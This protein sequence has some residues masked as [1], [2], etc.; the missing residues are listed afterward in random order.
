MDQIRTIQI[1]FLFFI[2]ISIANSQVIQRESFESN[3]P[4]PPGWRKFKPASSVSGAF[5]FLSNGPVPSS[6]GNR[7]MQFNSEIAPVNDSAF[8]ISKP[9]DFSACDTN[10]PNFKIKIYRDS[11]FLT[12]NDA[13]AFYIND[14]PDL[15]GAIPVMH[16][17][18]SNIINRPC[19]SF[20]VAT[21][22]SWNDYT[23]ELDASIHN[24]GSRKTYIIITGVSQHGR[25]IYL[26][27]FRVNT[28]PAPMYASDIQ[29]DV[30]FQNIATI[31]SGL[32]WVI[33]IRCIV[34]GNSGN[35]NVAAGTAVRLDSMIFRFIGDDISQLAYAFIV[36]S[37]GNSAFNQEYVSP[38]PS[39]IN[40]HSGVFALY[41]EPDPGS[42]ILRFSP[43][44]NCFHLEYD[45][46]YLWLAYSI[47]INP[48]PGNKFDA[49]LQSTTVSQGVISCPT[50]PSSSFSNIAHSTVSLPGYVI[51]SATGYCSPSIYVNTWGDLIQRVE[52]FSAEP[53]TYIDTYS[54]E[55]CY[56]RCGGYMKWPVRNGTT[57][58]LTRGKNYNFRAQ[59][60]AFYSL[61]Y[62]QAWIDFNDN[63][64]FTDPG[65]ALG[66]IPLP[67]LT[68]NQWMNFSFIVPD[69]AKIGPTRLRI[70]ETLSNNNISPCATYNYGETEDFNIT[71]L[72]DCP[73]TYKLWLGINPDWN[74][75]VNW[76][77]GAPESY[78]DVVIHRS[79]V[80]TVGVDYYSPV[81]EDNNDRI[82]AD[83]FKV[84]ET[85]TLTFKAV[86]SDTLAIING[87]LINNGHI[88]FNDKDSVTIGSDS[89]EHSFYTPFCGSSSDA[90]MQILYSAT[91][92]LSK[93]LS[94]GTTISE[95]SFYVI[96]V[97]SNNQP[98]KNST[99]PFSGFSVSYGHVS[100][101]SVEFAG[102]YPMPVTTNIYTPKNFNTVSGYNLLVLDQPIV[103][104]G[105]SSI[106]LQ[107]CFDNTNT[108]FNDFIYVSPTIG[109][110]TTLLLTSNN[111]GN[112]CSLIPGSGISNNLF[113]S[114]AINRPNLV[115][116]I[117]REKIKPIFSLKGDLLN[118][119]NL[120]TGQSQFIMTADGDQHL[121]SQDSLI[122]HELKVHKDN[123]GSKV[124]LYSNINIVDSL[125]LER[126]NIH[127]N[128]YYLSIL[129]NMP[130]TGNFLSFTGPVTRPQ[131]GGLIICEDT[132]GG[133]RWNI[134]QWKGSG[135]LEDHYVI[136]FG[137]VDNVYIP[138]SIGLKSGN[139][140]EITM[141]TF[142][143]SPSNL[144]YPAGITHLNGGT[145]SNNSASAADR[146]YFI[147]K[148]G[149][150]PV[151][152]LT[153]RWTA[154]ER[155]VNSFNFLSNPARSFP[156]RKTDNHVGGWL[157]LFSQSGTST[158]LNTSTPY[159]FQFSSGS[160]TDSLRLVNF[161]WPEVLAT[162]AP[163]YSPAG[164]MP[165]ELY[166]AI[167]G[168]NNNA[169][170][171]GYTQSNFILKVFIQ[172]YY[173]GQNLNSPLFNSGLDASSLNCDTLLLQLIDSGS[174]A[175]SYQSSAV[176]KSDGRAEFIFPPDCIGK[177]FYLKIK[178]RNSL[179]TWSK[180]PVFMSKS[181]YFN[182]TSNYSFSEVHTLNV[183]NINTSGFTAN[184]DVVSDGGT[185][186]T[187]RGI[188]WSTSPEPTIDDNYSTEGTGTG[189]FSSVVSG[190]N[191]A[192]I[193]YLR[194]Y[195]VNAVGVTYGS[196]ITVKTL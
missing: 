93:G 70:R 42:D 159:T 141:N 95:I 123:N 17:F 57:V 171:F 88:I 44:S 45:T 102:A 10:N 4:V 158:T 66:N 132:I 34:S 79:E 89:I 125:I 92:L 24:N 164:Q 188:C 140:G 166:W 77:F 142:R 120:V 20:P 52:F 26:D 60:G 124:V 69:D 193:Y 86:L 71:I 33:G 28:Y 153:F 65:E 16:Q 172:G 152:N 149:V 37:G 146:F 195:S 176:L 38:Y 21:A 43:V 183:N 165:S 51:T 91:E 127:L 114:E 169:L 59:A 138:F 184:C 96:P 119:G 103:W 40:Q 62:I 19:N 87:T 106:V 117:S 105:I 27:D 194:S 2:S 191:T 81:I 97:L 7:M 173:N 49:V 29:M 78:D 109:R 5:T 148:T 25:N 157:R 36:Y 76:C 144:P 75:P 94:A 55:Y 196:S 41:D 112:G 67:S 31:G 74:D 73:P 32:D 150:N 104:D 135:S 147:K 178:H 155:P 177:S 72:P 175:L 64:L 182:F 180:N 99:Q 35:G 111:T 136:P 116:H 189:T 113:T 82:R 90:R 145:G 154:S 12:L 107:F 46:T 13:V 187:Q 139:I 156:W 53:P 84:Y 100:S 115:F 134:G 108:S 129:N 190:L 11:T 185:S 101:D 130:V 168:T 6:H 39:G 137:S 143:T 126:G 15:Q 61:N 131:D 58:T 30:A 161:N 56:P 181:T 54:Q 1:I 162:G 110:R 163:W 122:F 14:S 48:Q 80:S 179:E 8:I 174:M 128:G 22:N 118:N 133:F 18:G 50:P 121:I 47:A 63:G 192:T 3:M 170:G 68:A 160:G 23:F 167:A 186:V 83:D 85:D 98:G 151:A 9:Y